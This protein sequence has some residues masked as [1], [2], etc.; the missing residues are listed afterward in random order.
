MRHIL[1]IPLI[2]DLPLQNTLQNALSGCCAHYGRSYASAQLNC[3]ALLDYLAIYRSA[4]L[5]LILDILD[6]LFNRQNKA[7]VCMNCNTFA[8]GAVIRSTV[9]LQGNCCI[10]ED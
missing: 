8:V 10:D 2:C 4:Q 1:D 3:G 5:P 9:F 7:L 6:S